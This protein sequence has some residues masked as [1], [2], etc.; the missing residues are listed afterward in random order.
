[1]LRRFV[2]IQKFAGQLP[3]RTIIAIASDETP[4]CAGDVIEAAGCDATAYKSD[5]VVLRDHDPTR[6][7]G[8][9]SIALKSG[10]VEAVIKFARGREQDRE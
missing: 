2:T 1:M 6:P 10:R 4:D 5:T 8:T 3:D 9:A 7:I